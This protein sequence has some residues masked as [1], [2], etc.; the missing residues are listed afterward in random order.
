MPERI[1]R[2]EFINTVQEQIDIAHGAIGSLEGLLEE[3]EQLEAN[4][5]IVKFFF[6]SKTQKVYF[7]K[8]KK[9]F[10]FL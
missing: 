3:I 10:G 4:G 6:D 9:K 5:Y 1:S 8:S 2:T 7:T